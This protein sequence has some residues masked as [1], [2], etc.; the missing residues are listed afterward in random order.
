MRCGKWAKVTKVC[1]YALGVGNL[2]LLIVGEPTTLTLILVVILAPFTIIM[3]LNL[4]TFLSC[5]IVCVAL[6]DRRERAELLVCAIAGVQPPNAGEEYQ[7]TMLAVISA[8]QSH[9]VRAIRANLMRTAP[10]TILAAW[11]GLSRP[12]RKPVRNAVGS[13]TDRPGS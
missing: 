13:S 3:A 7:E 10:G 11:V 1:G 4:T 6:G 8:A 12:L 2:M 9:K 5:N